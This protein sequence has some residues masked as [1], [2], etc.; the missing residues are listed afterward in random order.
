MQT[1]ACAKAYG[2]SPGTQHLLHNGPVQ[3]C[4]VSKE[5]K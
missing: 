5:L 3:A 4:S 1:T 2:L